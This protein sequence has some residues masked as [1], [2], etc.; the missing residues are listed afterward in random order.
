MARTTE[1]FCEPIRNYDG[2]R[3]VESGVM[4]GERGRDFAGAA[5]TGYTMGSIKRYRAV[6]F[7]RD[8][9]TL[10]PR[11][12]PDDEESTRSSVRARRRC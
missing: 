5:F 1:F 10:I 6:I 3:L 11:G 2:E 7:T 12:L 8:D 9:R 4:W